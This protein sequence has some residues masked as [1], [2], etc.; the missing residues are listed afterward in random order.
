ME[1]RRLRDGDVL[2]DGDVVLERGDELDLDT[3]CADAAHIR[4]PRRKQ[5]FALSAGIYRTSG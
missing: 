5:P 1:L 4:D 3:L 2:E